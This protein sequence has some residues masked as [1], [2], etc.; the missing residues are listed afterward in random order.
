M[1]ILSGIEN[2]IN[3]NKIINDDAKKQLLTLL[4]TKKQEVIS[5]K[6][7]A[8]IIA[9]KEAERIAKEEAERN[10]LNKSLDEKINEL[11]GLNGKEW[12]I[13]NTKFKEINFDENKTYDDSKEEEYDKQLF[14]YKEN[15]NNYQKLNKTY[16]NL[17]GKDSGYN[18]FEK[19]NDLLSEN[20]NLDNQLKNKEINYDNFMNKFNELIDED[21][22]I[23]KELS[24]KNIDGK[25]I[26]TIEL[27][28]PRSEKPH[29]NYK[30]NSW[31]TSSNKI[32]TIKDKY[33][34][35]FR[36][37]REIPAMMDEGKLNRV[38]VFNQ[39]LSKIDDKNIDNLKPSDIKEKD[40][41]KSKIWKDNIV[42]AKEV[43]AELDELA[44]NTD[45]I[46]SYDDGILSENEE[47]ID[48]DKIKQLQEKIE[49]MGEDDNETKEVL[50]KFLQRTGRTISSKKYNEMLE[51]YEYYIKQQEEDYRKKL[52]LYDLKSI[53]RIVD[54]TD[55][56]KVLVKEK[57]KKIGV[58]TRIGPGRYK[59]TIPSN[60]KGQE[61]KYETDDELLEAMSDTIKYIVNDDGLEQLQEK[62]SE[63][64]NTFKNIE[65]NIGND[66]K[67][68][69]TQQSPRPTMDGLEKDISLT[70]DDKKNIRNKF[71]KLKEKE[72][73]K[74]HISEV[75]K[76][77]I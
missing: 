66:D 47:E 11:K 3:D 7:Q 15:L 54:A 65:E 44:Q 17:Y 43:A 10:S 41:E 49:K 71:D 22:S 4:E 25:S 5:K 18:Q 55:N 52:G 56:R 12:D 62:N 64:I 58:L 36:N 33:I 48:S 38:K 63:K 8:E 61:Q 31:L 16:E 21:E 20:E 53:P 60:P 77:R 67:S 28:L 57:G 42:K 72:N 2:Q 50:N 45:S 23:K 9:K 24:D 73:L 29:P 76:K 6:E 32:K 13:L 26:V 59:V 34:N 75:V 39:L 70:D 51:K 68:S 74:N 30:N 37:T 14:L 27:E 69:N 19:L 1:N 46:N 35:F 40:N